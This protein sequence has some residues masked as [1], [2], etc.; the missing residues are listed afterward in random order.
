V[1]DGARLDGAFTVNAVIGKPPRGAGAPAIR[2]DVSLLRINNH[3]AC[4]W[5]F[6]PQATR[7]PPIQNTNWRWICWPTDR[8]VDAAR[9]RR[10]RSGC[11]PGS[12]PSFAEAAMLNVRLLTPLSL[13]AAVATLAP[14]AAQDFAPHRAI[15]TISALDRGKPGTGTSGTYAFELRLTCD[16]LCS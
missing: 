8:P 2:G 15:Y 12:N 11:S 9:L 7:A 4:G 5:P 10:L 16:W 13:L 14:A 3:G 6:L 1:F